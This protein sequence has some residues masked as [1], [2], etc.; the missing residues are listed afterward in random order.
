MREN[1]GK[2]F[3]ERSQNDDILPRNSLWIF[4][5]SRTRPIESP[6][7]LFGPI[8][9]PVLREELVG[10]LKTPESASEGRQQNHD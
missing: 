7:A 2:S 10:P 4:P 6:K 9:P 3:E 8:I 1:F 5:K